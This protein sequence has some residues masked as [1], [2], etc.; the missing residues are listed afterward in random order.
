MDAIAEAENE[1][2][3]WRM[4][5]IDSMNGKD[6][7]TILCR[8]EREESIVDSVVSCVF[9]APRTATIEEHSIA[10]A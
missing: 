5:R 2:R 3:R 1:R 4:N 9:E 10:I 8:I 6:W 7:K